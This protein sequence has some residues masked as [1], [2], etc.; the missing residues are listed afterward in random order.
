MWNHKVKIYIIVS[1][2]VW[3]YNYKGFSKFVGCILIKSY[4]GSK[5]PISSLVCLIFYSLYSPPPM[6]LPYELETEKTKFVLVGD[7][8]SN[9][10]KFL[11]L[12]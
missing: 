7:L 6:V 1:S 4:E 8:N 3:S 10:L 11:T 9:I 5:F 12:S 2:T